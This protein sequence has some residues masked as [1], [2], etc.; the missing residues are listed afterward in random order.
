VLVGGEPRT[1]G[2]IVVAAQDPRM[3]VSKGAERSGRPIQPFVTVGGDDQWE[4]RS[5]LPRE[6]E[7][8]HPGQRIPPRDRDLRL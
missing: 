4:R 3:L 5:R 7:E 8:A 1:S 6:Q 2:E